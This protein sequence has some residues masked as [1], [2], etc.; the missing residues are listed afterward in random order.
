[1][2]LTA[3]LLG[4]K[5][6]FFIP[7]SCFRCELDSSQNTVKELPCPK[8]SFPGQKYTS[9]YPSVYQQEIHLGP[10]DFKLELMTNTVPVVSLLDRFTVFAEELP[11][12]S[13]AKSKAEKELMNDRSINQVLE[14]TYKAVCETLNWSLKTDAKLHSFQLQIT[15]SA[16]TS[17]LQNGGLQC[18]SGNTFPADSFYSF[19]HQ[20][21]AW[22][23]IPKGYFSHE[24][25]QPWGMKTDCVAWLRLAG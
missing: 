22:W 17:S 8:Q 3:S 2:K 16:N 18:V 12:N 4:T 10:P 5:L 7:V 25:R 13:D 19:Q 11:L 6:S 20:R 15:D 14:G 1:M 9:N 24:E 21:L 23:N